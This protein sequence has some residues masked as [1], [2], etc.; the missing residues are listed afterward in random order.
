MAGV[1]FA[2]GVLDKLLHGD[3]AG[4]GNILQNKLE[5]MGEELIGQFVGGPMAT[6]RRFSQAVSTGGMSEFEKT[7]NQFLNSLKPR[8]APYTG[9]VRRIA[10]M[11]ES[12]ARRT[13]HGGGRPG[14]WQA[15]N[16]AKSRK[17]WLD[18]RW[19]HDWRSQPRD[20][21][22]KWIPGRLDYIPLEMRYRGKRVGRTILRRRKRRKLR[23]IATRREIKKLLNRKR[24]PRDGN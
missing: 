9:A 4:L 12:R 10:G 21:L 8:A 5:G 16:W 15:S 13:R 17:E 18:D 22:G 7:R 23:K 3:T 19:K 11:F 1:K 20:V 24:R 14:T 6:A 2:A